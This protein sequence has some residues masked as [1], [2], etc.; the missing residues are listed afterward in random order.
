MQHGAHDCTQAI[1]KDAARP[2]RADR[3]VS[4]RGPSLISGHDH[5]RYCATHFLFTHADARA[6][7]HTHYT[8]YAQART[9]DRT[10]A[11]THTQQQ[12]KQLRVALIF[13]PGG[14][15][16]LCTQSFVTVPVSAL[17]LSVGMH[18]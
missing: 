1:T 7:A 14:G 9:Q 2:N 4:L 13:L 11:H 3:S 17:F 12:Q 10:H 15:G 8:T 16:G 6:R 18:D 5:L